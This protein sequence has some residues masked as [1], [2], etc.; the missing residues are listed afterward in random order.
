MFVPCNAFEPSYVCLF[1]GKPAENNLQM[2]G[3]KEKDW[4]VRKVKQV[5]NLHGPVK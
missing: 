1:L 3:V 2:A 5:G 4:R